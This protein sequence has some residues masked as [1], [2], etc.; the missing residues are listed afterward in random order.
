MVRLPIADPALEAALRGVCQ[1]C[2]DAGGRAWVVGGAVRDALLERPV[3]DLDVE[4]HGIAAVD[5]E[6]MLAARYELDAVGRAFG[7]LKLRGVPLDVTLP[8]TESKSGLGHRG[9][10]VSSDPDLGLAAAARRRDFTINA[11]SYDPLAGELADPLGGR[12]DLAARRLRHCSAAFAE[13]P[14]R[15][16]RGM[17]FT[18]RFD[19]EPD[20]ATVALCRTIEP[21]GLA[22]ERVWHEWRKLLVLGRTPS[23]GLRFLK[24]TGWLRHFPPLAA[25]DGLP[26]DPVKHPE[27]DV[28]THVGLCLDVFAAQRTGD[29]AED[30]V[31]GLAVLCHDLGKPVVQMVDPD[32]RIR[33]PG[34]AERSLPLV[35]EFL[36]QLTGQPALVRE[37]LP[38]V[39]DH[40]RPVQLHEQGAGDA[41]VRRL[42]RDVGRIDRLLRVVSADRGGR[43]SAAEMH[44]PAVA[45]LAERAAALA[46]A[47]A[48]PEPLVLGRHLASRGLKPGPAYSRILR[49]CFEAQLDGRFAD[50][51]GGLAYLDQ[52]LADRG[53]P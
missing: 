20:P 34:H 8:R 14:L 5:L 47:D 11:I 31:V 4:V 22:T 50:L 7:V 38:L 39:R 41:A 40:Q 29:E 18:A 43:G 13:D 9:F 24:D 23:R 42:A 17:Q 51:T 36:E 12:A 2:R 45:W 16:L 52:L 10:L 15:V 26:Q 49:A 35:Q 53:V 44:P 30:V 21:E 33:T 46:V 48:R 37:V 25:L 28:Y 32:G 3:T 19:L 27:G 1:L 6:A